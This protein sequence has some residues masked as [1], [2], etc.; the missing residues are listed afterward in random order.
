MSDINADRM[1]RELFLAY[2]LD[3]DYKKCEE[4]FNKINEC[5]FR[6][7]LINIDIKI[8]QNKDYAQDSWF[9]SGVERFNNLD[10]EKEISLFHL[11]NKFISNELKNLSQQVFV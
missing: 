9:V 11:N 8:K 4:T 3:K 6:E 10:K 2:Y 7:W 1:N 5:T